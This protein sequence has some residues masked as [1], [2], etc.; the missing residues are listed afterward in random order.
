MQICIVPNEAGGCGAMFPT[1]GGKAHQR[2]AFFFNF[3][4]VKI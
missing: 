3:A 4:G 1:N 2:N